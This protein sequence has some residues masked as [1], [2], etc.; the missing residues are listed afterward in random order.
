MTWSSNKILWLTLHETTQPDVDK[1]GTAQIVYM[2][3]I[4]M[5]QFMQIQILTVWVTLPTYGTK[6]LVPI[7]L[8]L[9]IKPVVL[10][11]PSVTAQ[12]VEIRWGNKSESC[13]WLYWVTEKSVPVGGALTRAGPAE[14]DPP[15]YK[16]GSKPVQAVFKGESGALNW[17][18]W[19]VWEN[20]HLVYWVSVS[21]CRYIVA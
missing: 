5:T 20:K 4:S 8:V 1:F 16:L 15:L 12:V 6:Q 19:E 11:S 18:F 2:S 7:T 13:W 21:L 3:F 14:D 10:R 9:W 17:A